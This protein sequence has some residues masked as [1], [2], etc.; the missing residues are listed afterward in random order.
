MPPRQAD[1]LETGE[2]VAPPEPD[3]LVDYETL[4]ADKRALREARQ[5][6]VAGLTGRSFYICKSCVEYIL[7][8]ELIKRFILIIGIVL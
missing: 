5:H 1:R 2:P 6:T 8:F 3:A 7:F 4:T